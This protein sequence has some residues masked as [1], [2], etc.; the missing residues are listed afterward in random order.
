MNKVY[1]CRKIRLCEYLLNHGYR[2]IREAIDINNPS[3]KVWLF[4]NSEELRNTV[5]NY[6]NRKEFINKE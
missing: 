1:V 3:R 4:N 2:Y 6:Y 5:E